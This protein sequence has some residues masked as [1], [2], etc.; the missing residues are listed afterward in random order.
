MVAI[1]RSA[2]QSLP[3]SNVKYCRLN[4]ETYDAFVEPLHLD[5]GPSTIIFHHK[6]EIALKKGVM[7]LE[8]YKGWLSQIFNQSYD[9]HLQFLNAC[10]IG[11]NQHSSSNSIRSMLNGINRSV[12]RTSNASQRELEAAYDM[13]RLQG[14]LKCEGSIDKGRPRPRG[15]MRLLTSP[16]PFFDKERGCVIVPHDAREGLQ[17]G[18]ASSGGSYFNVALQLSDDDPMKV[19]F[20]VGFVADATVKGARFQSATLVINFGYD[21]AEGNS[22]D[23]KLKEVH[24]RELKGKETSVQFGLGSEAS[25]GLGVG[26]SAASV[27]AEGKLSKNASFSRTTMPRVRGGGDLTE[28][29]TWTFEEDKGEAGQDGLD[30]LYELSV[31]FPTPQSPWVRYGCHSGGKQCSGFRKLGRL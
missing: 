29:A 22:H 4:F 28:R 9:L 20:K 2:S 17:L 23:L 11:Y 19:I 12:S 5:A 15:L 3:E 8:Q 21:D 18:R 16:K 26:Y 14:R 30:R 1:H 13:E 6:E 31:V 7:E 25:L 27:T 24:P 10:A